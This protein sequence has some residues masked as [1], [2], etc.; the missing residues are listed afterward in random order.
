VDSVSAVRDTDLMVRPGA[1]RAQIAETLNAA[2]GAGL[3][4]ESTLVTRLDLLLSSTLI[5]PRGLVGD[6]T[7]RVP[8]G[9]RLAAAVKAVAASARE[10]I[11]A[12][13]RS[14]QQPPV[15][16]ALDWAGGR[17]ELLV[18]R[19]RSCDVV[20]PSPDVSRRHAQL[21]FRDGSWIL[22]DLESTNGTTVNGVL[23]GRCELHPGDLLVMGAHHLRID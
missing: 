22:R 16:L 15:L 6:L 9:H 12:A 18:G 8:R 10:L 4:S 13:T 3:L 2:Y 19:H 14:H 11:A 20:L 23:V 17:D 21:S 1:A 5:D 7:R